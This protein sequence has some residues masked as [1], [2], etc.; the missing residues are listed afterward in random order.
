VILLAPGPKR[1]FPGGG[2]S[3]GRGAVE[4]RAVRTSA[5]VPGRDG[6]LFTTWFV[7]GR[8]RVGWL[9]AVSRVGDF[10]VLRGEQDKS[11]VDAPDGAI[12]EHA[13]RAVGDG[14]TMVLLSRSP[15]APQ[16]LERP[17]PRRVLH[18]SVHVGEHDVG[19]HDIT[20]YVNGRLAS[21]ETGSEITVR[22]VVNA[23][24]C[25][26]GVTRLLEAQPEVKT[27]KTYPKDLR[28]H[29]LLSNLDT[30][31]LAADDP[32]VLRRPPSTAQVSP[33]PPRSASD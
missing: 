8:W 5:Y 2:L 4:V 24:A 30:L 3:A 22:D 17:T 23:M 7:D 32:I 29:V 1:T 19:K 13:V 25:A 21:F 10:V 26:C 11:Q 27:P 28:M 31:D 9:G 18:A 12:Y 15:T 6:A 33:G 16:C 20:E 14:E